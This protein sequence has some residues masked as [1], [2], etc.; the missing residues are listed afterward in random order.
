MKRMTANQR[1]SNRAEHIAENG[2]KQAAGEMTDNF[3]NLEFEAAFEKDKNQRERTKALRGAAKNIGIHPVQYGAND[4]ARGHQ[5][6]DVRHAREA[7]QPIG[8]ERQNQQSTEQR[9]EE[10][11]VHRN[12]RRARSGEIV[13]EIQ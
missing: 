6:D 7:H 4:H 1:D 11:Q 5:D 13:A 9:E 10:I 12:I 2:E 3:A 8:N